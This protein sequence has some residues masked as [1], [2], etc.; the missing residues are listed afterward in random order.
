[1]IRDCDLMK[2]R[3]LVIFSVLA[4]LAAF[5]PV[6]VTA[7]ENKAAIRQMQRVAA[8][9]VN[10]QK[11]GTRS[12]FRAVISRYADL[13]TIAN[14]SLGR[15]RN[16]LKR[17][18]RA[19]YYRGVNAFMGR[20]FSNESRR[21]KVVKTQINSNVVNDGKDVLINT[22]VKLSSG[23]TY[24]VVWRLAKRRSGYRITDVKVLGFSLTYLQRGMFSSYIRKKDGNVDAL[25]TAL[26]RHY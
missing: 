5:S 16:R 19:R 2:Q 10:A 12:A 3:I 14:Y 20:Y 8:A 22:K 4:L 15:Y 6:P 24:N 21:Y 13:P 25:I 18:R 1:M 9:L 11:I 7:A 23:S 17:S 26:N